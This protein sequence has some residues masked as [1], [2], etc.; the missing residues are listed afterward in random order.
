MNVRSLSHGWLFSTIDHVSIVEIPLNMGLG[1]PTFSPSKKAWRE[2]P[3][4]TEKAMLEIK[5]KAWT[6]TIWDVCCNKYRD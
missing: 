2:S 6:K 3:L 4:T 5:R 1:P